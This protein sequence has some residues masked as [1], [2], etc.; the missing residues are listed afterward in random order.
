MKIHLV[1]IKVCVV[2]VTIHIVQTDRSL[3]TKHLDHVR[4]DAR[5]VKCWLP[6]DQKRITILQ[7]SEDRPRG[8]P[9]P[10]V[11]DEV[12]CKRLSFSLRLYFQIGDNFAAVCSWSM[13]L[14]GSWI[15]CTTFH[16]VPEPFSIVLRSDLWI[17]QLG[18]NILRHTD[19]GG[20]DIRVRRDDGARSKIN[21]LSHHLHSEQA[22]LLFQQLPNSIIYKLWILPTLHFVHERVDCLLQ[23]THGLM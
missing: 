19:L 10:D 6:V 21:A 5:L 17:D 8:F 16:K 22:F 18:S 20:L 15:A 7:L 1:A 14:Q 2:G 9:T 3:S 23:S 4:H 13:H 12:L 11:C